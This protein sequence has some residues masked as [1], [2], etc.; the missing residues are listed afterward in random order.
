MSIA[1]WLSSLAQQFYLSISLAAWETQLLVGLVELWWA[2]D[3]VWVIF[4]TTCET[5]LY[6]FLDGKPVKPNWILAWLFFVVLWAM[7]VILGWIA[8]E[9]QLW[10]MA[11][12]S[13]LWNPSVALG[14]PWCGCWLECVQPMKPNGGM[15]WLC[16]LWNPTV[17]W[18]GCVAYE[19][20]LLAWLCVMS[21][22]YV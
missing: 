8:Y 11:W 22:G 12:L 13:S 10:R 17:R 1:L 9:T 5:Q 4:L 14:G 3:Q 6:I 2:F 18:I 19:T 7:C 15:D 21:F 16:S 20:H